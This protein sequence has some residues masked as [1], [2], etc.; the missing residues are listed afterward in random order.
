MRSAPTP[1]H[2]RLLSL[3]LCLL[4]ASS[5]L[6]I[7]DFPCAGSAD[8]Q[9]CLLWSTDPQAQG[10]ILASAACTVGR[11]CFQPIVVTGARADQSSATQTRPTPPCPTAATPARP[12]PVTTS[13]TTVPATKEVAQV[14]LAHPASY[15]ATAKRSSSAPPREYAAARTRR[16]TMGRKGRQSPSRD[17]SARRGRVTRTLNSARLR[18]RAGCQQAHRVALTESAPAGRVQ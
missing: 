3:A 7:G 13:A 8:S 11:S 4:T 1:S 15:P 6:A 14:M 2:P 5:A 10:V 9:S 18:H 17:S 16:A 12:A